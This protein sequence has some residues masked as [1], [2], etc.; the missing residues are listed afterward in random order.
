M[1]LSDRHYLRHLNEVNRDNK[2]V[3][4]EDLFNSNGV[5]VVPK[6]IEV[7]SELTLKVAKHK[8]SKP[9]DDSIALGSSLSY[10][11]VVATFEQRLDQLKV[12]DLVKDMENFHA[13][14]KAFTLIGKYPLILKKLSILENRMPDVFGR[15]LTA[16]AMVFSLCNELKLSKETIESAFLATILADVGLLHI[17]PEIVNKQG[18]Y[19]PEEWK[20]MQ[21][22]VAIA[23]HFADQIPSMPS[24]VG[25]A[26]LEHHERF[27]GFGYP[28]GKTGNELGI[29]GQVVAIVD[30][31]SGLV[32]K[33]LTNNDYSWQSIIHVMQIPSTAHAPELHNAMI[34]LLKKISFPYKP[35]FSR[36]LYH[37]LVDDC[38]A[39]RERLTLWFTEFAKVYDDHGTLLTDSDQFKPIGLLRKLEYTI[40]NTGLL[41][42]SQ[43]VWLESLQQH[44]TENDFVDIEEFK[45]LLDEIEYR[46]LFVMR[47][48]ENASEELTE[49][50]G[51][52][53]L[54]SAYRQGLESILIHSYD[55]E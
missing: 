7:N 48:F 20:M 38:I 34:R 44:R 51:G 1:E 4:S 45:L 53:A 24:E 13:V 2:V 5:L 25:R 49:R 8:L 41:S 30:K 26:L 12:L 23:K 50:F 10:E 32:K 29:A 3:L 35:A 17:A 6:G 33:L 37:S 42:E 11:A 28:F 9:I 43:H 19:T 39:K 55:T 47:K 16:S 15:A 27:D 21:G 46:C 14:K 31:V 18:K 40:A 52:T 36:N 54:L 22:H